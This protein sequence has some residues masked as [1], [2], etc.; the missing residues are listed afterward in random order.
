MDLAVL[1]RFGKWDRVDVKQALEEA[2]ALTDEC[3]RETRTVSYLLHPPLLDEAGLASALQW[4]SAG[5]EQRS[6][7]RTELDLP[8][9]LG[10]L[11]GTRKQRC[12][13]S[14]RSA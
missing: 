3:I 8:P 14:Y 11:P 2:L 5:F 10:R 9:T 6:G 13:A 4:Y 12:S 7:I 1:K